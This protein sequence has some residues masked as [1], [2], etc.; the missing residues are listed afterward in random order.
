MGARVLLIPQGV[1]VGAELLSPGPAG[2]AETLPPL[3]FNFNCG[4]HFIPCI[5]TNS[6]GRGIPAHYTRVIMGPDPHIIGIISGDRNQHR[7]P[8]YAIPD[9]NQGEH[10][11][12]AHDNLWSFKYGAD[13]RDQFDSTLE[14]LHDLSLTTKVACFHEASH[15]FSLYQEEICKI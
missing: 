11:Q 6:T 9:H 5:V 12:Y 8:L 4:D 15:L 1:R 10:P 7:G 14:Y 2:R 13:K 3:G